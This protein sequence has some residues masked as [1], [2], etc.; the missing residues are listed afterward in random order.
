ME[1]T[2]V[3]NKPVE[4]IVDK[5]S[6]SM[7]FVWLVAILVIAFFGIKSIGGSNVAGTTETTVEVSPTQVVTEV[8]TPTVELKVDQTFTIEA[9]NFSYSLKEIKVKK[10]EV[11]KIILNNKEGF[12]DLL[13]DELNVNTGQIEANKTVEVIFT[14]DKTG[15]FEYYCSVGSHRKNGMWGKIT[16]E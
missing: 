10:D 2:N 3:S 5:K 11:V 1:D 16:V 14:A 8:T 9:A 7:K 12:H 15:T 6:S 13:I 4:N